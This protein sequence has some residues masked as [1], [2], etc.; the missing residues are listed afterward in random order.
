VHRE[1]VADA[2]RSIAA[3]AAAECQVMMPQAQLLITIINSCSS[4]IDE[5]DDAT[6]I[7]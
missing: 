2:R 6:G 5:T 3:A 7:E 4:G 1:A